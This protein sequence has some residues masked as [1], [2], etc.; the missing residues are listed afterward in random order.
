ML[1]RVFV[2]YDA[3]H[4]VLILNL[5]HHLALILVIDARVLALEHVGL[6]WRDVVEF[7]GGGE[8][9][10]ALRFIWLILLQI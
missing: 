3:L 2:R 7:E 9:G 1:F 8:E 5:P 6:P 4:D 10:A